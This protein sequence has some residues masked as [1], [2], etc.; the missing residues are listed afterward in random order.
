MSRPVTNAPNPAAELDADVVVVGAGHNSLTAAAYLAKAGLTVTVLEGNTAIGGGSITEELTLPGIRH[1]TFSSG[2]VWLLTNP[3][4]RRD[5]L[6]LA[7]RGLQ[8]VGHDPVVVMPFDDGDSLTIWRDPYS[9]AEEIRRFSAPDADAWLRLFADWNDLVEVHLRR[10]TNPAQSPEPTTDPRELRYRALAARSARDLIE[11]RFESPQVRSLLAWFSFGTAQPIDVPGTALL[12]A[13]V[14]VSWSEFGWVNAVG[15]ASRLPDSLAS[16]IVDFGGRIEVDAEVIEIITSAGRATGVRLADGRTVH[17]RRAVLST[18]NIARLP[19]LLGETPLPPAFV[20]GAHAWKPGLSLFVTH[21]VTDH[22]PAARTRDHSATGSVL[23]APSAGIDQL[24][25]QLDE[26]LNGR[27]SAEIAY[28]F[29]GCHTLID[30]SRA[31]GGQG[32][33]KLI[34]FAPYAIDGDPGNWEAHREAYR[35]AMLRRYASAVHGFEPGQELA[36]FTLTPVDLETRNPSYWRGAPQGG[37]M[38]PHQL[39]LNRPQAGYAHYRM[40]VAGLYHTG[41]TAHPGA[42][43]SGWP[44]RHAAHAVLTDLGHDA[45]RFF[46][47]LATNADPDGFHCAVIDTSTSSVAQAIG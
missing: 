7:C 4:L 5:E 27:P 25:R 2:H 14:P 30:P 9:T 46:A 29:A 21:L 3:L 47:E 45:D 17:A 34:T 26:A 12:A 41:V 35:Q 42:P 8:Y 43:V 24:Q 18:A 40:P 38:L 20:E 6:G 16:L 23:V 37:E 22:S 28:L 13:S 36:S 31:P 33:V 32:V 39:G 15:G 1:D 11:E 44:G 19:D 10:V